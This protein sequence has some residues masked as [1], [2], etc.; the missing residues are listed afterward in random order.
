MK[1][2]LD[3][4]HLSTLQRQSGEACI[5]LTFRMSQYPL[6]DFAVS[7]IT[8]HEQLLG[9]HAYI[10]RAQTTEA[11]LE[12]YDRMKRLLESFILFSSVVPFDREASTIF[13]HLHHQRLRVATMD[14]RIAYIALSNNLTLLTRNQRDFGKVPNLITQDWTSSV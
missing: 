5:N 10:N 14:L 6:S 7:V 4:D 13:E 2:L 8:F 3:T 9:S 1:Y 12:G 11:L